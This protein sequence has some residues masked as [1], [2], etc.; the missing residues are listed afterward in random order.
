ME[1]LILEGDESDEVKFEIKDLQYRIDELKRAAK[2]VTHIIAQ[3]FSHCDCGRLYHGRWYNVN[4]SM[5]CLR[6]F[7]TGNPN[8]VILYQLNL[9]LYIILLFSDH[10]INFSHLNR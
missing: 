2:K 1:V 7:A 3:E 6:V 10:M 8:S 9:L 5:Q 4:V